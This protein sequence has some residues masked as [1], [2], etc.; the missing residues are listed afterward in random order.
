M[1]II[2][3]TDIH[4]NYKGIHKM[5]DF[6]EEAD[7][8]ILCGDLTHFGHEAQARKILEVVSLYNRRI[9]GVTGNCD[10][11]DV[12]SYLLAEGLSL[13]GRSES[14]DGFTFV[15][16]GGSLPAP[17]ST[18]NEFTEAE[19]GD[20]LNG[21][22]LETQKETRS[23]SNL[24]LVSHQPPVNTK[25]DRLFNGLHVGSRS[26]RVFIEETKPVVCFTGHI[27]EGR[28]VD[29]IGDTYVVNPGPA[30]SLNF[31]LVVLEENSVKVDLRTVVT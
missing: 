11:P 20:V 18:P 16:V 21:T 5:R 9:L 28:G 1:L 31:A 4:G 12:E 27:H 30:R 8:V 25:A 2:A 10:Y 7:M 22:L 17:G 29:S 3:L 19:I 23:H 24:V 26:V 15:G 6:L 14:C 13:H